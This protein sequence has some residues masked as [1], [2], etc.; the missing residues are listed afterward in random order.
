[1][2]SEIAHP[3]R[4]EE[5]VVEN[6][7]EYNTAFNSN[8]IDT[9]TLVCLWS[10]SFMDLEFE[11]AHRLRNPLPTLAYDNESFTLNDVLT[12]MGMRGP[13]GNFVPEHVAIMLGNFINYFLPDRHFDTTRITVSGKTMKVKLY[14]ACE[15]EL[16]EHLV[17]IFFDRID[18][19]A[20]RH[21][22]LYYFNVVELINTLVASSDVSEEVKASLTRIFLTES[23]QS[24]QNLDSF[25][26]LLRG[27]VPKDSMTDDGEMDACYWLYAEKLALQRAWASAPPVCDA[28]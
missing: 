16:M 21:M 13:E 25:I 11:D 1:M 10:L 23:Q 17:K 8:V 3:N 12:S 4:Y 26:A 22:N 20:P 14:M 24:R 28:V 6:S 18:L 5:E 9:E 15:R 19:I 7:Y 2:A 27:N